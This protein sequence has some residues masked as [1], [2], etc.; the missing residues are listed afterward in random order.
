MIKK[1]KI[2]DLFKYMMALL[3]I[4][5]GFTSCDDDDDL[6]DP[7]RLFRPVATLESRANN[8]VADWDN[9][10]GATSYDLELFKIT[11]DEDTISYRTATANTSP[12]TFE[13]VE[14]DEKYI[15]KIKAVGD[16]IESGIYTTSSLSVP[17]ISKIT[18]I[19]FIDVSALLSWRAEG[20]QYTSIK[21]VPEEGDEIN[22]AVSAEEF[23]GGQKI[24]TGLK[25]KT[26][27]TLYIYSGE[28]QTSDTYQGKIT[29]TTAGT[30]D[31]DAIYGAGKWFDLRG[32][33]DDQE[34]LTSD[35][36]KTLLSNYEVFIL[37]GGFEYKVTS[38][39][40]FEKSATFVT[41]PSL[42][43][44]AVF[45]QS[46]GMQSGQNIGHL[47]FQN[48]KFISDKAYA[49]PISEYTVKSFDG[50]QVYNVNGSNSIVDNM[51]FSNCRIE[52]YRAVVRLQGDTDGVRK[53]TFDGCTING[54]GDQGVV[55][56]NNKS[57][58]IL[59]EVTFNNSTILNIVML[60][61]LRASANPTKF[62]VYDCTFCYAP[63]ETTQNAN[64]PLFRLASNPV[65]LTIANSIFGPSM[66]TQNSGGDNLITYT[67]GT[68]GSIMMNA[69][70]TVPSV[71]NSFKTNFDWAVIGT[72][73]YP[74]EALESIPVD[75]KSLF[76]DT[77]PESE[78]FTIQYNFSGAK[79]AGAL[80]WRME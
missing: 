30:I 28:E 13:S 75:E 68:T 48:I 57:G 73:T 66:A 20:A 17:F 42:A 45:I 72:N 25:P 79:T 43:G 35:E 69:S 8:L 61:D 26:K 56:T 46:G 12:Y 47:I 1:M 49:K 34:F 7:P 33:T 16:N 2:T 3:L 23:A 38:A 77:S 27:Y 60:T 55:T 37:E 80:K 44:N 31:F 10:K 70:V 40:K 54:V 62:N 6:G 58:A 51:I 39:L 14:W 5:A 21:L 76:R 65:Q 24:I 18:S 52:G 63:I 36:M 22:V 71:S 41:G 67:A 29:F 59:D 15:L 53:L 11:S 50:R 78:N 9:I 4:G 19:R 74:I 64:T 32:Y